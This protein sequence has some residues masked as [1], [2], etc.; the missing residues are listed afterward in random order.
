MAETLRNVSDTALWVA[1]YRVMETARPDALFRDP[2]AKT[3][4]GERGE[5]LVREMGVAD[6]A[7]PMIVRTA[8]MD[9]IILRSIERE[10][11]DR[12]LNLA[13]GL[14]TRPYRLPL[15]ASL[16]W[17]E[18]DLP[19]MVAYKEEKLAA[20]RPAVAL[21][22]VAADLTDSGARRELFARTARG[23]RAVLVV[24]EGLLAYLPPEGVAAL[25]DDLHAEPSMRQWLIDIASPRLKKMLDRRI[26]KHVGAANAPFRFAPAEGT[27]FFEPHG[28][29]EREFRSTFEEGLRLGRKPRMAW[30]FTLLSRLGPPARRE[31]LRR[32]G[33][34]VLLDRA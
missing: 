28:W 24:T 29:K 12:V 3:L 5:R 31:E 17:I 21:E 20:E 34:I 23:A 11:I 6:F 19:P 32:M 7:W 16:R 25:A 33:G 8:V 30:L 13:A 4:A 22:R 1:Q 27:R 2:L 10:G 9:E 15:P 18:A 14:D 26:G